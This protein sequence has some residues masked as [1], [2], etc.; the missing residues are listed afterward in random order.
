[1]NYLQRLISAPARLI[2]VLNRHDAELARLKRQTQ[3]MRM[4]IVSLKS[5]TDYPHQVAIETATTCNAHCDFCPQHNL[6]RTGH[7]MPLPLLAQ[8]VNEI[9]G[10]PTRTVQIALNG[11]NEPLADRHIDNILNLI[12][13]R[14]PHIRVYFVTNGNLLTEDMIRRLALYNLSRLNISLNF[15]DKETYE[16]R[17]RLSW[18]TTITAISTLHNYAQEGQWYH[19][20]FLSRVEDGSTDDARFV[21][22]VKAHYPLFKPILKSAADWLGSVA[23]IPHK[24]HSTPS[25]KCVQWDNMHIASTG[26]IRFCCMDADVKYPWGSISE[27]PLLSIYNQVNWRKLRHDGATRFDMEPCKRCTYLL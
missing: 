3:N 13:Q 6:R 25:S 26:D 27:K 15:G 5:K 18:D 19:P 23:N 17:M 7:V 4:D 14:V 2:T 9:A 8:V 11:I 20:V 24:Y 10:W 16:R 21:S 22:F 1:M 12:S